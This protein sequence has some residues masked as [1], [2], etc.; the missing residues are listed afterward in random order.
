MNDI[1]VKLA[2]YQLRLNVILAMW[3]QRNSTNLQRRFDQRL[4]SGETSPARS[5]SE[6]FHDLR[7]CQLVHFVSS[8]EDKRVLE[9]TD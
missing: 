5:Q 7:I 3:Q 4:V 6:L 8:P 9:Q 1:L 2:R